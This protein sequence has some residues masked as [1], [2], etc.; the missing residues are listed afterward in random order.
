MITPK[1]Q[2]FLEKFIQYVKR[3]LANQVQ[4]LFGLA[5]IMTFWIN[6]PY[7]L[8]TIKLMQFERV[9]DALFL[10][11][12]MLLMLGVTLSIFL[13]IPTAKV[14]KWIVTLFFSISIC[15]MYFSYNY[16]VLIDRHMI[17]NLVKTDYQEVHGLLSF[18]F[19]V[20][21]VVFAA[22]AMAW[23]WLVKV[24]EQRSKYP[25]PLMHFSF[26]ILAFMMALVV[27]FPIYKNYASFFRNNHGM[28]KALV[29]YNFMV[30]SVSFAKHQYDVER[31]HVQIGLDAVSVKPT[32]DKPT[33][34]VVVV[35][36]T[37]RGD[38][39]ALNGYERP[40]NPQL[41]QVPNVLSYDQ[42]SSCGTFTAYSV[43]C[44]FSDLPAANFNSDSAPYRDNLLDIAQRAGV[45]VQWLDNQSG[46][47]GT[48]N[49]VPYQR[50]KKDCP[51]GLCFDEQLVDALNEYLNSVA[52][53][54]DQLIV[55]HMNGSHGPA[56]YQRYPAQFETF[57]P[58]CNTNSIENCSKQELDNVY[59][60]TIVYTD[61]V[62]ASVIQT[63]AQQDAQVAM[64]YL[65]DHGESLGENGWY[66][67]GTPY[68]LAPQE[69]KHIPMIFWANTDF[70]TQHQIDA[71]CM[72][73]QRQRSDVSQD[74]L[75][76]TLLFGLDIQTD[77]YQ[78]SLNLLAAC[79]QKNHESIAR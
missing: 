44:M 33:I 26:A 42:A 3:P 21:F 71:Q 60:N 28:V 22:P 5:F 55:L 67:H 30:A 63:L 23:I 50:L 18:K 76:H 32:S 43:P 41:S 61:A 1:P 6:A 40:T 54:Q 46:C 12:Q 79:Q 75:F 27:S 58:A 34:W 72:Q 77:L 66:L 56:Y 73:E 52:T 13:L 35:G 78:S 14:S 16:Q 7:W 62:L 10:V 37:A 70:Y 57:S 31:T 45:S 39:F 17:T 24:A 48:C 64:L 25:R 8:M 68:R 53:A 9:V 74:N 47:Q 15:C 2:S 49:R 20:W 4:Y 38:R 36:E 51:E 59:D 29:P 65:S 69:Q 11:S 19:F